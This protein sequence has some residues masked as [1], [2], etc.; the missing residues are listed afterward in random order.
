MIDIFLFEQQFQ[1]FREHVIKE[2]GM[3][4]T[5]F[6]SNPYTEVE[7]GYKYDLYR[8]ARKILKFQNWQESDIGSGTIARS[9]VEAIELPSNNLV[10]WQSRYGDNSRPHHALCIALDSFSNIE[11][12]DSVFH[13]LYRKSDDLNVFGRLV[14]LFGQK[15]PLIA[16]LLFLKDRNQYMPIAPSY[17]DKAF[18]LL[19]ESFTTSRK[20][21]WENYL[22][23]NNILA[24]LKTLLTE[25]LAGE[26]SLLDAH[27]FVWMISRNIEDNELTKNDIQYLELPKAKRNAVVTARIGQGYFRDGLIKYWGECA[28]TKC[29]ELSLLRASH[30]KPYSKCDSK[31]SIDAFNGFLLSPTLDAA[32]DAGLIS[33]DNRGKVLIS[34]QLQKSDAEILGIY[35]SLCLSRI[36]QRHQHYLTYH[37]EH[38][39]RKS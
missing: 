27:S 15:Y 25:K 16:Y 33:F 1:R 3:D 30:I 8:D 22:I 36:E 23:F 7:E 18:S 39:F 19:G 28:V 35:P 32:F 38:I 6:S 26:V 21:S 29:K 24:D 31:E 37:R 20:C 17:F 2:S 5:S 34:S 13:S 9:V 11:S 10:Q 12:F 14:N 4:L